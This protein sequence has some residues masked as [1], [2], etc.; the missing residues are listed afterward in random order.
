LSPPIIQLNSTEHIQVAFDDLD[1]E[2]MH[3]KYTIIHCENDWKTSSELLVSD[4]ISGYQEENIEQPAYSYN[5]TVK[6]IHY[7]T[8]FPTATMQPKISGNYIFMVYE[9]DTTH[10]VFTVRFMVV[11]SAPV[12]SSGKVVQSTRINDRNTY[13]Q[14]DFGVKLNGFRINDVSREVKVVVQQNG[15]WD[16]AIWLS[17]PRFSRTDELDYRY[18]ES[19]AFNGGNQFRNFDTKSLVAQS[20]RI[21]HITY[22][23][24]YQVFLLPDQPRTFKQYT[25]EKDL[26][27]KYY[28]K[29]EEHA[30]DNAIEADYAWVHFF[31]PYPALL[32]IGDFY[33]LGALTD[34][35]MNDRSRLRFNFDRKGY[36]LN[37]FLKQGYYN[38]LYAMK[39][40][41]KSTGDVSFIEGAH[42]DAE[43]DYNIYVYFR[44]TGS[45][46]DRLIA[47][48]FLNT[49]QP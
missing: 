10:V 44:E 18:D 21:A 23:T 37:L 24:A 9:E 5:T 34:W 31:L 20:E 13:Q 4:Y 43:N 29:N 38:Y 1:P 39:T 25:F 22:D 46:F 33:I 7:S 36:E 8:R 17:K 35:Q 47:V 48:N 30:E 40:K 26:N 11:E 27:G 45:T 49:L 14:I 6:Y 12:V 2:A 32:T 28:I 3:F 42:W 16:N 15:R 41:D 19:I